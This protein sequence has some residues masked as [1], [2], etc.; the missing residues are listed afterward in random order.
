MKTFLSALKTFGVNKNRKTYV[1]V[2]IR[3]K[4]EN[5]LDALS[6]FWMKK[7]IWSLLIATKRFPWT[8]CI[9]CTNVNFDEFFRSVDHFMLKWRKHAR[10]LVLAVLLF[11]KEISKSF[12]IHFSLI[13]KNVLRF[14][15]L[16][17]TNT[18]NKLL[19]EILFVGQC[20]IYCS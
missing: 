19:T 1:T 12:S 10:V 11:F 13:L 14:H 5:F 2:T 8:L 17:I 18:N 3:I 15:D 20:Y 7:N 9:L 6:N 4:V 16:I